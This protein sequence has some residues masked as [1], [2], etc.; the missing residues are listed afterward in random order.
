M[1]DG[2]YPISP[3]MSAHSRGMLRPLRQA[4]PVASLRPGPISRRVSDARFCR[5]CNCLPLPARRRP[6]SLTSHLEEEAGGGYSHHKHQQGPAGHPRIGKPSL[7]R[8]FTLI[9]FIIFTVPAFSR[10]FRATHPWCAI[11]I[12]RA[13]GPATCGRSGYDIASFRNARSESYRSN[14]ISLRLSKI[15]GKEQTYQFSLHPCQR[16]HRRSSGICPPGATRQRQ[17]PG[18][19]YYSYTPRS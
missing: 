12:R 2:A 1:C 6:G 13:V 18:Q 3:Y 7:S 10:G 19:R 4:S 17:P 9:I 15:A 11:L 16:R 14:G 8:P 5:A